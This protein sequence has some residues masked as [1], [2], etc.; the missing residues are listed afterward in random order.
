MKREDIEGYD[1]I[2]ERNVKL[3]G[4]AWHLMKLAEECNELSA[5]I[6]QYFTKDGSEIAVI[7]EAAD[8]LVALDHFDKM[9]PGE[10]SQFSDVKYGKIRERLSSGKTYVPGFILRLME[11]LNEK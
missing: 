11:G 10:L 4:K 3:N 9:Y 1:A 5:A 2:L 8:V 6:M 7:S